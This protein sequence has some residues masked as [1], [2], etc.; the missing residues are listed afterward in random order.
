MSAQVKYLGYVIDE[1]GL[2]PNPERVK[3]IVEAPAPRSSSELKS[4][5]GLLNYYRK[6]LPNLSALLCPLHF[7]L[8][9]STKWSWTLAHT[10]AFEEAKHL[11]SSSKVLVHFDP[12]KRAVL[13]CDASARGL[14]AV[15][16]QLQNDGSEQPIAYTS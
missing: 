14:G 7:L 3:A 13:S 6:F 4:F 5:L 1:R 16:A 12:A 9:A 2:H 11:L 15:L 8:Q 10:K